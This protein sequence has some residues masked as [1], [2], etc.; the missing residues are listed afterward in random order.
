MNNGGQKP[1]AE[2]YYCPC[3]QTMQFLVTDEHPEL[4]PQQKEQLAGQMITLIA[5]GQPLTCP[6]CKRQKTVC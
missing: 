2:T 5:K 6:N 1:T 4:T 3:G